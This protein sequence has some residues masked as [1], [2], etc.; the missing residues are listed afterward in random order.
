MADLEALTVSAPATSA[1]LGP[2]F[3]CLAVALDLGNA[4][5]ISR[6]PGP[7][8]VRVSGEGAGELAEDASNL[9]CR[10]LASGLG[11]LEGLLVECRNRIPLGRGLGSSSAAACAGLV[12]A[13]ALGG[14]RWTPDELL[15]RATEL[16]G[17]ADNA[18]ACIAGGMVAVRPGPAAGPVPAPQE[19]AFVVVIPEARTST[20][21]ARRALPAQVALADAAATLAN[22]VALTLALS[23]GR[24]DDVAD[25]LEDRLHE[26]HRAAAVPGIEALRGLVGRAGCL[27]ATISGSGPAMLLWCRRDDADALAAEA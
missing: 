2:G 12:A 13:N 11:P 3:D 23:E 16:E 17:H 24:L 1:N 21:A 4:V 7:L 22:A 18:A 20:D 27:G 6:R 8:A 5:I 15:A 19:L 14:L 25:L 26:P 9:V 10:A